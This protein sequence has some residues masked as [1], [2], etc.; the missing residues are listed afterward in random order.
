MAGAQIMPVTVPPGAVPGTLLS[1][2][3]PT[4]ATV[5]AQIPD[6]LQPG[7]TFGIQ[8]SVGGAGSTARQSIQH[9]GAR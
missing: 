5:Q 9:T 8:Y 7:S 2:V 6:G 1:V 4:G 3:T